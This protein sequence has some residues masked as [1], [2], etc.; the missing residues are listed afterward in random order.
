MPLNGPHLAL[1]LAGRPVVT[2]PDRGRI[3]RYDPERRLLQLG[4][5]PGQF[6]LPVDIIA[7]SDGRFY[8]VDTGGQKVTRLTIGE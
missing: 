7:D 1:D 4:G 3:I 5:T 6:V 2:D 8:V